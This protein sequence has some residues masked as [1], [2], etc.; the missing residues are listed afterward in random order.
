MKI[1]EAKIQNFSDM[2]KRQQEFDMQLTN[3][4]TRLK[5]A[6]KHM[7]SSDYMEL[8]SDIEL[9][10]MTFIQISEELRLKE[11]VRK[12]LATLE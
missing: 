5:K 10:S 7:E 4:I 1:E 9:F 8:A 2:K 3:L 6:H 11:S 12:M